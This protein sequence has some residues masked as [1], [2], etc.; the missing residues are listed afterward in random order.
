M[1]ETWDDVI[2]KHVLVGITYVDND[3]TVIEQRQMHGT[4]VSANDEAVY[5]EVAGLEEAQWL[6]PHLEAYEEAGKGD[7]RLRTTGEV[8]TDPDFLSTWTIRPGPGR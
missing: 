7:Y 5:I 4:I 1:A 8:V 3:D 6:P 2:G